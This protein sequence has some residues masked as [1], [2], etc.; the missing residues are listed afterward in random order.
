MGMSLQDLREQMMELPP[1]QR[2]ELAH[3]LFESVDDDE[4]DEDPAAV[5]AAWAEEIRRRVDDL[6]AGRVETVPSSEVFAKA[7]AISRA[8]SQER[9]TGG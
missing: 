7:R 8:V 2:V 6:D 4:L 1:D 3:E 9:A 5:E